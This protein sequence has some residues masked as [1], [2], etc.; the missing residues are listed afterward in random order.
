MAN[1]FLLKIITP[2]HEVYNGEVEKL[3]LTNADGQLAILANHGN[4][5]TSTVPSVV[6]FQDAKGS[7]NELFVSTSIVEVT[8]NKATVCSD[9]AEFK[10]EI[11]FE[12][13]EEAKSRAERRLSSSEKYDKNRAKLALIRATERLRL[14]HNR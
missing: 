11:D 1:T 5:I 9:A 3:F 12:R 10:E 4:L 13:A 2:S 6:R 14:K 8:D 7:T